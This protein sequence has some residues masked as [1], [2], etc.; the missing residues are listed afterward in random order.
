MS[1]VWLLFF[2]GSIL[3]AC[4]AAYLVLYHPLSWC[5]SCLDHHVVLLDDF[6]SLLR[7]I[8]R[9]DA[10]HGLYA[11]NSLGGMCAVAWKFPLQIPPH[12]HPWHLELS[13]YHHV[14]VGSP[15]YSVIRSLCWGIVT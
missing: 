7:H 12:A 14:V 15:V 1:C 6:I 8:R 11:Q 5:R 4:V 2:G 9:Q 3:I 13:V 10:S